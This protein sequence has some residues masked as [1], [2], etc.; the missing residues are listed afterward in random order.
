LPDVVASSIRSADFVTLTGEPVSA[1]PPSDDG[2]DGDDTEDS[3]IGFDDLLGDEGSNE[4]DE[5]N[6]T[7][8]NNDTNGTEDPFGFFSASTSFLPTESSELSLF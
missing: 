6:G 8:E 2:G 1:A 7:D 4:T 3:P 5:G